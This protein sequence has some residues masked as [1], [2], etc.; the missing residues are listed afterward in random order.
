MPFLTF[1]VVPNSRATTAA[2]CPRKTDD[3]GVKL[4]MQYNFR[5]EHPQIG[6]IAR[7]VHQGDKTE[8]LLTDFLS[9]SDGEKFIRQLESIYGSLLCRCEGSTPPPSVIDNFLIL[10]NRTGETVVHINEV[11]LDIVVRAKTKVCAGQQ[12]HLDHILNVERLSPDGIEIPQDS[13]FILMFSTGWR[14]GLFYDFGPLHGD[15]TRLRDFRVDK[16][17]A[18]CWTYVSFSFLFNIEETVWLEMFKQRWFPFI[19]LRISTLRKMIDFANAHLEIDPFLPSITE[20]VNEIIESSWSVWQDYPWVR[21]HR[22]ILERAFERYTSKD[23]ISAVSILYPRLEGLMRSLFSEKSNKGKLTAMKLVDNL[24][25]IEAQRGNINSLL[26]PDRF[27]EFLS[28]VYFMN[29]MP[30]TSP[31]VGRHSVSH[32]EAD[33]E[34]FN[35]KSATIALLI[36]FQMCALNYPGDS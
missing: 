14:K 30:G 26:L 4:G 27:S 1:D 31:Q 6:Y 21:P 33:Q 32:G 22:T 15:D 9:T 23:Y 20:E 8:L 19:N 28:K 2:V 16:M 34:D 13:G 35:Q 12:L 24:I 29:F 25:R 17:L 3:G 10:I 18:A 11:S 36:V 7:P 5:L